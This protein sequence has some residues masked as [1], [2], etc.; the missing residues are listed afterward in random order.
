MNITHEHKDY[1][2]A[3]KDI[4]LGKNKYNGGYYCSKDIVE[5]IMPRVKTDRNWVT[6]N[7][8]KCAD[9]SLFFAHNYIRP[10]RYS[11]LKDYKDVVIVC[12][13]NIVANNLQKYGK[14]LLLPAFINTD[15]VKQFRT[16]KT[17]G[18]AFVGRSE[19]R[20][21]YFIPEEVDYIENLPREELLEKMAAY[22]DVYAIGR[23]ALEA[24]VLG[25]NIKA[26]NPLWNDTD[27]WHVLDVKEAAKILQDRLNRLDYEL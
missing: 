13:H 23:T 8:G 26:F 10:E 7:I 12:H 14:C 21:G 6:V 20:K 9:H 16:E 5:E 3:R 1:I 22:K 19:V 4:R 27:Y 15:Y 11:F 24:K 17:K 18:A 25:C 2:K